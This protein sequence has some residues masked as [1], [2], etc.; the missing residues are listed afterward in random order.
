MSALLLRLSLPLLLAAVGS[1]DDSE[2]IR[3]LLGTDV[4]ALRVSG[5]DLRVSEA[6]GSQALA[7]AANSIA[8][9]C[10]P[11]FRGRRGRTT[12][13]ADRGSRRGTFA[14]SGP[15]PARAGRVSVRRRSLAGAIICHHRS[16]SYLAAVAWRPDRS[17]LS[18]GSPQG[19]QAVAARSYALMR[20][21]E[22]RE[23]GQP[24]H[25]GATVLSAGSTSGWTTRT[26]EPP[27]PCRRPR[28]RCL[29]VGVTPVEAYFP[30]E[31]WRSHRARCRGPRSPARL[32][33]VGEL[34]LRVSFTLCP[35]A[36]RDRCRGAQEKVFGPL[37]RLSRARWC[38]RTG[39]GRSGSCP[40]P[41]REGRGSRINSS[42]ISFRSR[43]RI[44]E[45][46]LVPGSMSVARAA[47]WKIF[48]GRGSG[49]G[50]GL[51]QWGAR[52]FAEQGKDYRAILEHYYPGTEVE[53]IY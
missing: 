11:W 49:H 23:A 16:E 25:L 30:C 38:S 53:R 40:G 3:I 46:Y 13:G 45:A 1:Q 4:G 22:A 52:I 36:R 9:Y 47:R 34:P 7:H 42:P 39:S 50:A 26:R 12:G 2:E 19:T 18:D 27:P 17:Q 21:I 15:I 14:C 35:L 31:L 43:A 48:E 51:C 8:L 5:P 44:P 10:I 20:K 6:G 29:P 33:Q 24:Y 32:S 41:E 37:Q 28:A